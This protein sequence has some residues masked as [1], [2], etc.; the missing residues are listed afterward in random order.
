MTESSKL[1]EYTHMM[2]KLKSDAVLEKRDQDSVTQGKPHYKV[3]FFVESLNNALQF[4]D[5]VGAP[6][7]WKGRPVCFEGNPFMK[8]QCDSLIL[9][10]ATV[11]KEKIPVLVFTSPVRGGGSFLLSM[12][13]VM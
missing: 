8:V 12:A 1:F 7:P 11:C 3:V 5:R 2:L 4:R 10:E 9:K 6:M 13:S